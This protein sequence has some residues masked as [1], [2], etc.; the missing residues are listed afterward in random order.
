[1]PAPS[2]QLIEA[3]KGLFA[4]AQEVLT[5]QRLA[6][7]RA[8]Y[9]DI[10]TDVYFPQNFQALNPIGGTPQ[11]AELDQKKLKTLLETLSLFIKYELDPYHFGRPDLLSFCQAKLHDNELLLRA[12][13][14]S[15]WNA[16]IARYHDEIEQQ[17]KMSSD[18]AVMLQ[19]QIGF[20]AGQTMDDGNKPSTL[21]SADWAGAYPIAVAI[22]HEMQRA[23]AKINASHPALHAAITKHIDED[24]GLFESYQGYWGPS[25]T[26]QY[27]ALT[28]LCNTLATN[29]TTE[30]SQTT[31]DGTKLLVVNPSLPYH[32]DQASHQ[33]KPWLVVGVSAKAAATLNS[34]TL[35]GVLRQGHVVECINKDEQDPVMPWQREYGK[36]WQDL[37]E[38][39]ESKQSC[40]GWCNGA[41]DDVKRHMAEL[42]KK[43]IED[44]FKGKSEHT[45]ESL[46]DKLLQD[47]NLCYK[48]AFFGNSK[49]EK[50]VDEALR[51]AGMSE[52][53]RSLLR[54]R[55]DLRR[56]ILEKTAQIG[57]T[58]FGEL[59]DYLE[60]QSDS[61]IDREAARQK[62]TAKQAGLNRLKTLLSSYRGD[63][64]D[65]NKVDGALQ[66]LEMADKLYAWCDSP[67]ADYAKTVLEMQRQLVEDS[68]GRTAVLS[69]PDFSYTTFGTSQAAKLASRLQKDL[70]AEHERLASQGW[71][72][73]SGPG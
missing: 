23:L 62:I 31:A 30:V 54:L 50:L 72:T 29:N 9:P 18:N 57:L 53:K 11:Q 71:A 34:S 37:H 44:A 28:E 22:Y 43:L 55:V 63:N 51:Y 36:L 61:E 20:V 5:A 40:V 3:A 67:P 56:Y 16:V 42:A 32:Q 68:D 65:S 45:P 15:H 64:I 21:D 6:E 73:P 48:D 2:P 49:A 4:A 12:R 70:D 24:L 27:R 19:H 10:Q 7:L 14:H 69:L 26:E 35:S 33:G 47:G 25:K 46:A 59:K 41:A 1:M 52:R 13:L 66:M 8:Y 58:S 17:S 39:R 38:Y 60:P